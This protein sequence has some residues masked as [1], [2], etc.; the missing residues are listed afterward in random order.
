[1]HELTVATRLVDR[2]VDAAERR[3]ADRVDAMTVE[4]G[5]A[6]HLAADQVRF[7]VSAVAAETPAADAAVRFERVPPAGECDCGWS[8]RP[9]PVEGVAGDVPSLRC[10]DCG[11]RL[12]LTAG[13]ECRLTSIEIPP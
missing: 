12:T 4:L 3:G 13:R 9:D 5:T 2:A 8:G 10:P 1:M 7:C 11:D 6:T